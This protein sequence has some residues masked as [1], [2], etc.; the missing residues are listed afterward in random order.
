LAHRAQGKAE[1]L[2][3]R[4]LAHARKVLDRAAKPPASANNQIPALNLLG[5]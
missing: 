5:V 2:A 4:T 1:R 3:Q